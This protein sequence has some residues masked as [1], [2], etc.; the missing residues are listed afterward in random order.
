MD[1]DAERGIRRGR[2]EGISDGIMA[3]AITL[4]VLGIDAPMPRDGESLLQAFD[5]DSLGAIALFALS[6]F[7]IA[8]FWLLHHDALDRLPEVVPMRIVALNFAFLATICLMPFSTE[9][10]SNH[11]DDVTAV[12]IYAGTIALASGLIALISRLGGHPSRRG[13]IA[14]AVILA[15]IPFSLVVGPQWAPIVWVTLL[16]V[17]H[18]TRLRRRR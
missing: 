1:A 18:G 3:V 9:L 12:A 7:L 16:V 13:P 15:A 11:N 4:L 10:Y 8:R 2:L 6:F 5:A 14:I 17:P